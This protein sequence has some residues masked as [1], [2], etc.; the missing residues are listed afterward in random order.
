M[1][2]TYTPEQC[3]AARLLEDDIIQLRMDAEKLRFLIDVLDTEVFDPARMEENSP[4]TMW[5]HAVKH[6]APGI[7]LAG[8]TILRVMEILER[9]NQGI[10]QSKPQ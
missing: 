2:L 8:D 3:Q 10:R 4:A 6:N 7:D 5:A 9:M 1:N